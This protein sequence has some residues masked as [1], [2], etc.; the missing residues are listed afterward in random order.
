MPNRVSKKQ[1]NPTGNSTIAQAWNQKETLSQ[2]YSRF[3][4]V[5]RLGH[6]AGGIERKPTPSGA[7]S[8][9]ASN[10]LDH[11][12]RDRG[13]LSV[14]EV[15]VERDEEGR[16]VRVVREANPLQDPLNEVE[17]QSEMQDDGEE[18]GGIEEDGA[19]KPAVLRELE[20]QA[21]LPEVKKERHQSEREREW[22]ERLKERHGE[23]VQA[24]ARDRKLNPMQQTVADIRKRLR[25]AGLLA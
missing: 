11:K 24:M 5:S 8:V 17:E 13:L 10:P 14:S 23:D 22:L 4:I 16:I 2:N 25:K 9:L 21:S 12:P 15:K 7:V 20:R 18:W 6:T 1:L 3:G 19:S